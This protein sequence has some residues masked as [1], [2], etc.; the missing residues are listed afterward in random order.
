[1]GDYEYNAYHNAGDPASFDTPVWHTDEAQFTRGGIVIVSSHNQMLQDN[2]TWTRHGDRVL[3]LHE[4]G[5]MFEWMRR[6]SLACYIR[7]VFIGD[8][9]R[10]SPSPPRGA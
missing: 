9:A 4:V 10:R 1:M 3:D 8:P 2:S 6:A 5:Q 7:E